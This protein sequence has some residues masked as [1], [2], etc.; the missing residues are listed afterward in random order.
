MQDG[1]GINIDACR[2]GGQS[3]DTERKKVVRKARTKRWRVD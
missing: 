3:E 1:T 2:V